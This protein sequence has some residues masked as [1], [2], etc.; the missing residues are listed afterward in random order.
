MTSPGGGGDINLATLWIPVVPETS[1]LGP[2]LREAGEQGRRAFEEGFTSGGGAGSSSMFDR[3]TSQLGNQFSQ[4]ITEG[5]QKG[6]SSM[7]LPAGMSRVTES[8]MR[9]FEGMR[10]RTEAAE[11]ALRNY[12]Q[13]HERLTAALDREAVAQSRVNDLRERGA[14]GTQM[15]SAVASLEAA[16]R[17]VAQATTDDAAAHETFTKTLDSGRSS[18]TAFAAETGV[19][20]GVVTAAI[21]LSAD[22]ISKL[23][24]A[25]IEGF[26]KVVETGEEVAKEVVEIGEKFEDLNRQIM[27]ASTASGSALEELKMHADALT[28]SLDTSTDKVGADMATLATRLNMEA[29]PALDKLTHDVEELRDRFGSLDTQALSGALIQFGVSGDRA[30]EVLASLVHS[31]RQFGIGLNQLTEDLAASGQ[32]LQEFDLS[33]EQAGHMLAALEA[34]HISAS[35]AVNALA[36]AEKAASEQHKDLKTFVQDEIRTIEAYSAAGNKA[37]AE[38]ESLLA[39]GNKNWVQ[40]TNAAK[41]YLATLNAGPDAFKGNTAEMQHFIAMTQSLE[42]RWESLR[43]KMTVAFAPLASVALDK[44]N[45]AVSKLGEWI[46]GHESQILGFVKRLGEDF[47]NALPAV[48]TFAE[49][50]I[51]ALKPIAEAFQYVGHLMIYGL[52][53]MLTAASSIAE[54]P[55]F[56]HIFGGDLSKELNEM[57]VAV[58]KAGKAFGELDIGGVLGRANDAIK[59]FRFDTKGMTEDLDASTD[60][61]KRQLDALNDQKSAIGDAGGPSGEVG[62]IA[63]PAS[64]FGGEPP[65]DASA[66]GE[67]QPS[68]GGATPV[69]PRSWHMTPPPNDGVG[70]PQHVQFAGWHARVEQVDSRGGRQFSEGGGHGGEHHGE[71]GHHAPQRVGPTPQQDREHTRRLEDLHDRI[72]DATDNIQDY[73][74]KQTDAGAKL[75]HDTALRDTYIQG[76]LDWIAENKAVIADQKAYQQATKELTRTLRERTRAEEDIDDENAKYSEEQKARH[77][78]KSGDSGSPAEGFGRDFLSGLLSDFGIGNVFG[79]KSPLDWAL[80]KMAEGALGWGLNALG[81]GGGEGGAGGGGLLGPLSALLHPGAGSPSA[82]APQ[83]SPFIFGTHGQVTGPEGQAPGP[84]EAPQGIPHLGGAPATTTPPAQHPAS[85]ATPPGD[86]IIPGAPTPT[87]VPTPHAALTPGMHYTGFDSGGGG[88]TPSGLSQAG[89]HAMPAFGGAGG[90]QTAGYTAAAAPHVAQLASYNGG[91]KQGAASTIYNGVL[92]AGYSPKTATAAVAAAQYESG[93]DPTIQEKGGSDHWGLFQ[94]QGNYAGA[95]GSASDQ[96]QWFVDQLNRLGGPSVVDRDPTN[97][98]ADKV[99]IGG[100]PGSKYDIGAASQLLAGIGAD[101]TAGGGAA[102]YTPAAF[103]PAG[104]AGGMGNANMPAFDNPASVASRVPNA[105]NVEAGIRQMGGLPTLYDTSGANAYKVPGWT[106]QLAKDFGLTASTYASGGSL[107]QMG[108]AFDFNGPQQNMD[109]F[110]DYIQRNLSPQTLQLI[111]ASGDRRWGIASGQ[112]VSGGSYYAG[113][114]GGHFDHVH[115]ATDVPPIMADQPAGVDDTIVGSGAANAFAPAGFQSTAAVPGGP[116]QP[117]AITNS[118]NVNQMLQPHYTGPTLPGPVQQQP[119]PS[120]GPNI[121][122]N[123]QGSFAQQSLGGLMSGLFSLAGSLIGNP[124]FNARNWQGILHEPDWQG[125]QHQ[126]QPVPSAQTIVQNFDHS[127]DL[128]GSTVANPAALQQ[129]VQEM[130]NSRF[131]TIAGGLPASSIGSP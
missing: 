108:Y 12:E 19:V 50:A 22:A 89:W 77:G 70:G 18:L 116:A 95:H 13:T 94:Q 83:A 57:G 56:K 4:Q 46:Q 118:P 39:F 115:W 47:I 109:A 104:F 41:E 92:Q 129:S 88:A 107:H 103:A 100:Y 76:S 1:Q 102:P 31:S 101:P 127:I 68:D 24:E 66:G 42:N 14:A 59:N 75:Q 112:D 62:H 55:L 74:Q 15:L 69:Q 121:Q 111:H 106:Q 58:A 10:G 2:K 11:Q 64:A 126:H 85:P 79:G 90:V 43:N 130:M 33:A 63:P 123:P 84:G 38:Q 61:I 37:A 87:P 9:G 51:D 36:K 91:G 52:S 5:L 53:G 3:L 86:S 20:G 7:E 48:Q 105:P 131:N 122:S 29:G 67:G 16:H 97:T 110:A 119:R 49:G 117:P 8:L 71:L 73:T 124:D 82:G 80:P 54:N 81:G 128:S 60:A 28:A 44:I 45:E 23:V 120:S 114:Y 21:T 34:Q 78:G 25:A 32:T 35:S 99:E 96:T 40:S 125:V 27:V 30:D 93:L 65:D 26:E 6:L 17:R 72:D 98:I 113:D